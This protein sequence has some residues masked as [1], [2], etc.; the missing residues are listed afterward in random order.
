MNR[1]GPGEFE[2]ASEED[3]GEEDGQGDIREEEE[4]AD[5]VH[6]GVSPLPLVLPHSC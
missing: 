1:Y 3:E 6:S 5:N 4:R 2:V